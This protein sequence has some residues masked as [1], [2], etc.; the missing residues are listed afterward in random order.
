MI[1]GRPRMLSRAGFALAFVV[2][3]RLAFAQRLGG[4]P[5][6]DISWWRVI[7]ALVICL[8]LAAAVAYAMRSRLGGALA[9]MLSPIK[10]DERHLKLVESLR[11]SHQID[12]CLVDC[13]GRRLL[14]AASPQ[15]AVLLAGEPFASAGEQPQ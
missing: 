2:A 8:A 12:V 7:G 13:E 3:P 9:P 15:G 10:T 4:A 14:I 11:L 5:S 1:G 6:A